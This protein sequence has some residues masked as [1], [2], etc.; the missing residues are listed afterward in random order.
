[1]LFGKREDQRG[2]QTKKLMAFR[3]ILKHY[4]T[5]LNI[6]SLKKLLNYIK[7]LCKENT[8]RTTSRYTLC[9]GQGFRNLLKI[10]EYVVLVLQAVPETLG[11]YK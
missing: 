1:M 8:T 6:I 2:L 7:L 3:F 5:K 11:R 9:F 10:P 4:V